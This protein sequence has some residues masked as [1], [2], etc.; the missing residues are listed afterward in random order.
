MLCSL[1]V[2]GIHKTYQLGQNQNQKDPHFIYPTAF[3]NLFDGKPS[4]TF[5]GRLAGRAALCVDMS[6]G[7]QSL[8]AAPCHSPF[9]P[10]PPRQHCVLHRLFSHLLLL[11]PPPSPPALPIFPSPSLDVDGSVECE[12]HRSED[13]CACS[14]LCPPHP[15]VQGG[16]ALCGHFWKG[17]SI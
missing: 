4:R 9:L 10:H 12:P 3:P 1:I 16:Q 2:L 13:A 6:E 15:S 14:P 5:Q 17:G 7:K 8:S 11:F